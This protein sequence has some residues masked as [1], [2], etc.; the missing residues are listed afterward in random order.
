MRN[1]DLFID[2]VVS[3][4]GLTDRAEAERL[5]R[6]AL[7]V[8]GGNL[9]E[10]TAEAV[11]AALPR[12]IGHVVLKQNAPA[13]GEAFDLVDALSEDV[14]IAP[15]RML[16]LAQVVYAIVGRALGGGGRSKLQELPKWWRELFEPHRAGGNTRI[17]TARG[18]RFAGRPTA[19]I[20][21]SRAK[22][23]RRGE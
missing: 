22:P 16:E 13:I 6:R 12:G 11:A 3:D 17:P 18:D 20:R 4:T 5:A 10:Y 19:S 23:R 7:E 1:A 14:S 8:L 15:E 9:S 2:R 21:A